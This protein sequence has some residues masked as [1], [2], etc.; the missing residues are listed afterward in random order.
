MFE[1]HLQRE[2]EKGYI[3]KSPDHLTAKIAFC[4]RR[5]KYIKREVTSMQQS[6]EKPS[7]PGFRWIPTSRRDLVE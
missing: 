1:T 3:K 4:V 5:R 2:R 7:L 6:T